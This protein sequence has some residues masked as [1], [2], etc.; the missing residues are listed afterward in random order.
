MCKSVV[1]KIPYI[2]IRSCP[3]YEKNN[4]LC[5]RIAQYNHKGVE[6]GGHWKSGDIILILLFALHS[7][8]LRENEV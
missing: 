3:I 5:Y 6:I 1:K 2:F 8:A 4:V 7:H